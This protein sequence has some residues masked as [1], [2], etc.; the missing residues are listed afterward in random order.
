MKD[1]REVNQKMQNNPF[2]LVFGTPPAEAIERIAQKNE[3]LDNFTA[4]LPSQKVY[5]ITGLR[6]SGKTVLMA[7]VADR[8]RTDDEWIVVE[9]NP[10]LDLLQGLAAKL[11]SNSV[12][13][14]WFRKAKINLS[15]LG[16]GLEIKGEPPIVDLEIAVARMLENIQ[17]KGKRLLVTIDEVTNTKAMRVFAASYQI[18]VRQKYPIFLLMTGLYENIDDLQNEKSLTFLYR[19][20]KIRLQPLNL[21]AIK[22]RY[23]ALFQLTDE[24]A[25]KMASLTRGY[26]FAFQVLGYL[27]WNQ[28]GDYRAV[29]EQYKRYLEDYVYLKI[30]RELSEKDR[31]LTYAIAASDANTVKAIKEKA[32]MAS[33]EFSIYRDRLLKKELVT[34]DE[35]GKLTFT[36]PL[37]AD[38]VRENAQIAAAMEEW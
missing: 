3:I 7:A 33:N 1:Y 19:A 37:F 17:S 27:T 20:P 18:F 12:Y 28:D 4:D 23:Q 11:C 8:L 30:W 2:S 34:G 15:L 29:I 22:H 21:I 31:A 25:A 26:S 24:D 38:F 5:I 36:L 14:E 13:A 35:R 6:G 32:N 10:E 16:F 9:L